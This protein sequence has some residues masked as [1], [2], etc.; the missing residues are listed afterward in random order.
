MIVNQIYEPSTWIIRLNPMMDE[1]IVNIE[2]EGIKGPLDAPALLDTGSSVCVVSQ[3]FLDNLRLSDQIQEADVSCV[4]PD[5]SH[6]LCTGRIM[7]NFTLGNMMYRECFYVLVT[8][9]NATLILGY[10][11]MVKHH[12]KITAGDFVSNSTHPTP[13]RLNEINS[14]RGPLGVVKVR[15]SK[16]YEISPHSVR[17]IEVEVY[18][19]PHINLKDYRYSPWSIEL[20]SQLPQLAYLQAKNTF[21][22]NVVNDTSI[23]LPV[24]RSNFSYGSA[25]PLVEVM[26]E[27]E[28][29]STTKRSSRVNVEDILGPHSNVGSNVTIVE[30][31]LSQAQGYTPPDVIIGDP[32]ANSL[33]TTSKG[34][35]PEE[36]PDGPCG[37]CIKQGARY[38]CSY[39]GECETMDRVF[40]C[41]PKIEILEDRVCSA[42]NKPY[43]ETHT[44][45]NQCLRDAFSRDSCRGAMLWC[46][47]ITTPWFLPNS[48]NL[49]R[50]GLSF[51]T[52]TPHRLGIVIS[53]RRDRNSWKDFHD[54]R[55]L[56]EKINKLLM[57]HGVRRLFTNC[58]CFID[59]MTA[60]DACVETVYVPGPACPSGTHPCS[61]GKMSRVRQLQGEKPKYVSSDKT[62]TQPDILTKDPLLVGEYQQIIAKNEEL[63]SKHSWDIGLFRNPAT[64][65]PF[66]FSYRLKPMA[67]PFV[68]KFRPISPLK[69]KPAQEMIESL[70]KHGIIS[71][72]I[73]PWIA[74]SVWAVKSQPILTEEQ[75]KLRGIPWEGQVDEQAPI[76]LR[77]T[78]SYVKLNGCLEFV[79]TPLPNIKKLFE[80]MSGS[81]T[82]S[83]LDLTWSYFSL[84]I[85][86]VSATMTGF[87]SGIASDIS[88]AFNRSPMGIA[89]SSGFLQASVTMALAPVKHYTINYSDNI[90]IHSSAEQHP[91]VVARTLELLRKFGFKI[92]PN[93]VAL[94]IQQ[95]VKVLGCIFDIRTHTIHPDPSKTKALSEMPY[96]TTVT[97]LKKFLGAFQFM[98]NTMHG[99]ADPLSTLYKLTRGNGSSFVFDEAAKQAFDTL[100]SIALNPANFIYFVNYELTIILRCDSSTEAVGWTILQ[101]VPEQARYVS[102]GY[103]V[104]CFSPTQQRYGASEREI[105]GAITALKSC[106]SILAG[107]DVIVQLD[108]RGIVLVAAAAET[109]SKM[110]RYLAYIQSFSPPLKFQW[111]SAKDRFFS[112][113]DLLSRP[114]HNPDLLYVTNTNIKKGDEDKVDQVARKLATGMSTLEDFPIVLDYILTNSDPEMISDGSIFLSPSKMVCMYD[115]RDGPCVVILQRPRPRPTQHDVPLTEAD[116][117]DISGEGVVESGVNDNEREFCPSEVN[118]VKTNSPPFEMDLRDI[119][120]QGV[121]KEF[122]KTLDPTRVDDRFLQFLVSKFPLL[123]VR[124][125]ILL[126]SKDTYFGEI[127]Q[128][129]EENPEKC[130]EKK[131]NLKFQLNRGVLIRK[132]ICPLYGPML[133]LCLPKVVLVD[134]LISMHRSV[135]NAHLGVKRL[136]DQ[137]GQNFFNPHVKEYATL[138]VQQCFVCGANKNRTKVTRGNYMHKSLVDISAPGVF[139]FADVVQIVSKRTSDWNSILTFSDGYSNYIVP[140]PFQ[141]DMT[142]ELFLSLFE[143]R[144]LTIFPQTKIVLTDNASNISSNVVKQSLHTMNIK[145]INSRPYSSKSNVV[146]GMQRLLLA[147]IRS[148][149]QELNLPAEHWVKIV[150]ACAISLNCTPYMG[151]RFNLSPHAVQFG[152][153]PVLDSLFSINPS[154]LQEEGYDTYVVQLAKA[155]HANALVMMGYRREKMLRDQQTQRPNDQRILPG[156][157]VFRHARPDSKVS[158][159]KL[160]PRNAR[161][162]LVLLC[163]STS[164][165]CRQFSGQSV[166]KE[167]RT[168]QDFLDA[169]KSKKNDPL[170]YFDLHHFDIT[171]LVRVKT[172]V[173]VDQDTKRLVNDME[174]IEFPGPFSVE[175]D[176]ERGEVLDIDFSGLKEGQAEIPEP[177]ISKVLDPHVY[178]KQTRSVLKKPKSKSKAVHFAKLSQWFEPDGLP[179]NRP[180]TQKYSLRRP[181]FSAVI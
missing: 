139:W 180:L 44:H 86:P 8:R 81:D 66:T 173:L 9:S 96:P 165:Y 41:S 13:M 6:L 100:I 155:H 43:Q 57:S 133:Q 127:V 67:V 45:T 130:W 168:F 47:R 48:H 136:C 52:L 32:V 111:V 2:F 126:Q 88:L 75:A 181:Q 110:Q 178:E 11:F 60:S 152:V 147:S 129:C 172:L 107:A 42:I 46:D 17:T 156:D 158:N 154:L 170:Q 10:P 119:A 30:D 167:M 83:C 70:L 94:H 18:D 116:I 7:L 80:Q 131:A 64:G 23:H 146:E 49:P 160:R 132:Y 16:E 128:K 99:S 15:P 68:A 73:C 53:H 101:F 150:P 65:E 25:T 179:V 39:L 113:A 91:E 169:P 122:E 29:S 74:N 89:P 5:G 87:W 163:T 141:G 26:R 20:E 157:I 102:C 118:S 61:L 164:A 58:N 14:V 174:R 140:I 56:M 62:F 153:R 97:S 24:S 1:P 19:F 109:N 34:I 79:P 31:G 162:Y 114:A 84:Q 105:L 36:L 121:S 71:R 76:S 138:V 90:L 161:L 171:D 148:A 92:K 177:C 40:P 95:R 82:L 3:Q 115:H 125:L 63:F 134:V 51:V 151:I 124:N 98:V 72:R 135:L 159:Y 22:V 176:V 77:L 103:G 69:R 145:I 123:D 78:V 142:N 12:I 27:P 144:I 149:S 33:E 175:I 21:S 59:P 55:A 117:E 50:G 85:C 112:V 120:E 4:G 137:F 93:K 28:L 35:R 166:K 108:C 37:W 143:N 38:Y 54:D 106:E 104:K